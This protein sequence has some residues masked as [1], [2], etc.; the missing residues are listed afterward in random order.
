MQLDFLAL[1]ILLLRYFACPVKCMLFYAIPDIC[2]MENNGSG[3][4][5]V[6]S[7]SKAQWT[8]ELTACDFKHCCNPHLGNDPEWLPE[9]RENLYLW[10]LCQ[11]AFELQNMRMR[12]VETQRHLKRRVWSPQRAELKSDG[13]WLLSILWACYWWLQDW[14]Q[15]MQ[16]SHELS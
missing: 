4:S 12:A 14:I 6:L 7:S 2:L 9:K 10:I 3:P 1:L 15:I 13:F 16:S 11:T 8:W 5:E